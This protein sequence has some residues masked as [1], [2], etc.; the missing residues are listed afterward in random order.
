MT[1]CRSNNS[2]QINRIEILASSLGGAF[3]FIRGLG[4]Y[5]GENLITVQMLQLLALGGVCMVLLLLLAGAS[6]WVTMGAILFSAKFTVALMV[7]PDLTQLGMPL[8]VLVSVVLVVPVLIRNVPHFGTCLLLTGAL[9]GSLLTGLATSR[10]APVTNGLVLVGAAAEFIVRR[11]RIR[12][13]SPAAI[14]YRLMMPTVV[15]PC[16]L[17]FVSGMSGNQWYFTALIWLVFLVFTAAAFKQVVQCRFDPFHRELEQ[18][19]AAYLAGLPAGAR[20]LDAGAGEGQ[21]REM[22]NGLDRIGVDLGVGDESWD[23][24]GLDIVGDLHA[25]PLKDASMDAVV[26]TVTMEHLHSPWIAIAEMGRTVKANGTGFFVVPFM[27]ELHQEPHDYFRYSPHAM[28]HL[29]DL[30]GFDVSEIIS[31]GGLFRVLHYRLASLLKHG[32]RHPLL[33]LCLIPFLPVIGGYL[34][35]SGIVDRLWKLCDHTLG[36]TVILTKRG[37]P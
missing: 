1:E 29:A 37:E 19:L 2:E 10:Y 14:Q 32:I 6:R 22:F 3:L 18:H 5:T 36:Y 33:L 16:A 26:C 17:V 31:M 23:Y 7:W 13:G 20:V 8:M 21:Y 11:I 30:A 12:N 25:L 28:R 4:L 35:I 24:T 34:L 9:A 15:V 27:W